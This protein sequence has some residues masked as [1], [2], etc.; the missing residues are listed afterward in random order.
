MQQEKQWH[1]LKDPA[2]GELQQILNLD[3][4]YKAD[5][6]LYN[7]VKNKVFIKDEKDVLILWIQKRLKA[8]G[9]YKGYPNGIWNQ[10]T[11]NSIYKMQAKH[12]LKCVGINADAWY[13]LLRS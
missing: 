12:N 13:F 2:I 6:K 4:T 11:I 1:Y 7:Y 3:I 10:N 5:E 8:M 9:Y